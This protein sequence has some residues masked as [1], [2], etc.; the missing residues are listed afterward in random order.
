MKNTFL[1]TALTYGT[2]SSLTVT[3]GPMAS[4]VALKDPKLADPFIRAWARNILRAADVTLDVAGL[5][6]LPQEGQFVLACN[7]QSHFD[8]VVLF[9]VLERHMRFVAKAELYKIPVFGA[10][11][12]ITGNLRVDRKG[13]EHDREVMARA[14]D[15][16]RTRV[17]IVFFAEG[18]RSED[19]V[20]R[21]FKKGAAVLAISAQVPI[22]PVALAGTKE[23]LR[24]GEKVIHGGQRVALRVGEPI[25]PA[26]LTLDDRDAL[27]EEAH[28]AVEALLREAEAAVAG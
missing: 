7:H 19:G 2:V 24:K 14:A 10:A 15:A 1:S 25:S 13:T 3:L 5:E 9:A 27:T 17:S 16:V 21:P 22:V 26:G 28:S 23:I 8:P 20:L 18:T 6:K 4:L 11:M 12:R